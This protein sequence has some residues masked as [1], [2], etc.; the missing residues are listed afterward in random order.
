MAAPP[1]L[2][3]QGFAHHQAGRSVAARA[4]YQD[5]LAREPE[6]PDA[7]HLLGLIEIGDGATEAGIARIR[8]AL[9][10]APTMRAA[11]GNLATALRR[12]GR[13]GEALDCYARVLADTPDDA[14]ALSGRAQA[15]RTLGRYEEALSAFA[16]ALG[17]RPQDGALHAA[18]GLVLQALGRHAEAEAA[19]RV[20]ATLRPNDASIPLNL[21]VSLR[22]L[23]RGAEVAACFRRAL[24]LRPDYPEALINLGA[25]ALEAKS[26]VESET[27]QRRALT[28]RPDLPEAHTGLGNVLMARELPAQA[29]RSYRTALALAPERLDTASNLHAAL[30]R[31]RAWAE[32][33][34]NARAITDRHPGHAFG[35]FAEGAALAGLGR[36][37]EAIAAFR[38]ALALDPLQHDAWAGI[39]NAHRALN[40]IAEALAAFRKAVLIGPENHAAGADLAFTQLVAGDFAA[41]LEGYETR[42]DCD[43]TLTIRPRPESPVWTGAAPLAGR[44]VLVQAEQGHGDTLQMLRYLPELARRA[45]RVVLEVQPALAT[46]LAGL[47]EV[48]LITADAPRPPHDLHIP[49]MSLAR[50]FGTRLATIPPPAGLAVAPERRRRWAAALPAGRRLIGVVWAGNPKHVNDHNRSI[51]LAR[52][53]PIIAAAPGL[54]VPLQ[55]ERA[56]GD[57]ALL[58]GLPNIHDPRLVDFAD[59]AAI[60]E[61]LDLVITVDTAVAHLA[62]TLGRPVWTLLPFSPDWRWLLDRDDTPWYPSMRL[63]RQPAPEDWASV[64]TRVTA[65]LRLERFEPRPNRSTS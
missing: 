17:R 9:A 18:R 25:V 52:F 15:L 57:A 22:A 30:V 56:E 20:A 38:R 28:L 46:L 53:R 11:W 58:A 35:P 32:V 19:L 1:G 54:V 64:V 60:I 49:M 23:G 6:N 31:L 40:R 48:T 26:F 12:A 21:G 39:G 13:P 59:T 29:A 24:E 16:D 7:L 8:R 3:Q 33:L 27:L 50:A 34:D 36:Y 62:G 10:L 37:D 2:L 61:R 47:A 14:D 65:E 4:C 45:A 42:W 44:T 43:A 41:G 55:P 5:V 51:G 63:F